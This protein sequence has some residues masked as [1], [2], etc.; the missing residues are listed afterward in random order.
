MFR[1]REPLPFFHWL[2]GFLWPHTGWRRAF[3][4][5][6]K[7]LTRLSGTPHSI[8]AGF[9]CGV[10]ISFTPL[11][12]FHLLLGALLSLIVRGNFLAMVVGTLVGN[13]WTLP[14]MWLGSYEVGTLLLGVDSPT[15]EPLP[16]VF[17][18]LLGQLVEAVRTAHPLAMLKPLAAE[19]GAVGRPVLLGSIPLGIAAGV[20]SYLPLVRAVATYR[21][22]RRRRYGQR[23]RRARH[24]PLKAA[25]APT[26]AETA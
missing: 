8:A 5:Y 19:L 9:A 12:G 24:V 6:L 26:D 7:R 18:D 1:R 16:A 17:E 25:G 10:A 22:A 2:R 4:Y 11:V 20:L 13:P 21:E 3:V 14:F 15:V 23:R